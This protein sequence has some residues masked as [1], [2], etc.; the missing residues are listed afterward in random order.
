MERGF[1]R[2][3]TLFGL[4]AAVVAAWLLSIAPARAQPAGQLIT[5]IAPVQAGDTPEA[6]MAARSR[7]TCDSPQH[8]FGPGNFWVAITFSPE[9]SEMLSPVLLFTP[10][11]YRNATL[12]T[13]GPG[14][15]ITV[16]SLD[17]TSIS[18]LTQIGARIELPL[19][20]QTLQSGQVLLKIEGGLNATGLIAS[21]QLL[22]A[23]AAH[24]IE[25]A[26]M[27][28][29]AAFGGLCLALLVYNLVFW[30]TLRERF[31]LVYCGSVFAMMIYAGLHSGLF[32]TLFP[33]LGANWRFKLNYLALGCLAVLAVRF[34][35]EFL[36][37]CAIPAWM[38]WLLNGASAAILLCSVAVPLVPEELMYLADRLYVA[39]FLPLPALA[40]A[41]CLF[42]WKHD[43]DAVRVLVLAWS[44]PIVMAVT[45]ILHA[46]NVIPHSGLI[47]H[48]VVYA[49]SFEA[50]LS[51][52]AVS[53]RVRHI[54]GER[55][56]ARAEEGA[57]R[58]LSEIDPLTGLQNRRA[59]LASAVG[60]APG[61]PLRLL[62]VDIDFFK[63]INDTYGHEVGDEV[64]REVA[65]I[66]ARNLE[67]RGT[68]ARMGGEEF[69]LLGPAED[70]PEDLA[71]AILSEIRAAT[72]PE[73]IRITVSIGSA[74]GV[75]EQE[76]DWRDLYRRADAAL[77]DAKHSGR[78]CHVY[79]QAPRPPV[80][81][82]AAA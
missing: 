28:I 22:N 31:Q 10:N 45:R 17:S 63:S 4:L 49:M 65:S 81:A 29:Y 67:I 20:T 70:L 9:H 42:G 37:R 50:L 43:R 6:M 62:L 77:Y 30:L 11:Y 79:G 38:R 68:A 57:A 27:A 8:E 33:A 76:S 40:L 35:A 58:R 46:L 13:P 32:D 56:L 73:G 64:L 24:Q 74:I 78:N 61:E 44:L 47:E 48:S 60:M 54:L 39:S 80:V 5:C 52:F 36:P 15:A 12:Y 1:L 26:E 21:P 7:F 82:I 19:T 75:V 16:S 34:I 41:L 53:L 3:G 25:L 18:H 55:D 23:E 66:L 2:P 72:M 51:S 59:L 14:G 69:A 71:M